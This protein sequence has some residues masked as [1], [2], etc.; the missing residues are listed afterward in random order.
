MNRR[1]FLSVGAAAVA[2]G[3]L[4]SSTGVR[5]SQATDTSPRTSTRT[6][7]VSASPPFP[8]VDTHQHL[9]DLT[10]FTLPWQKDAPKLQRSFLPSDYRQATAAHNVAATVYMEVDVEVAQQNAEADYVLELCS[11]DDNPMAGA[12]ISGRPA[13]PAFPQYMA[14]FKDDVQI[15]GIR[16]VLHGGGTPPGFCLAPEFVKGIQ[17]LGE[18]GKS[19]DLCMRS[20]ELRDADKLVSQCPRT[21]FIVDHCGNMSVTDKDAANRVK[22]L[23]GMKALAQRDNVVC[24]VSGIIASAPENWTPAD[25]APNVLDTIRVFGMDRVMFAGDWPVCT[26]RAELG[27]WIDCL[28]EIVKDCSEMDRAKLFHDNAVAFYKLPKKS[29]SV[30]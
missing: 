8:I 5:L 11:R 20:G 18:I 23:D 12:V 28:A 21:R 17:H 4:V 24:K 3:S 27:Q 1:E 22:W 19:F 10:R 29:W 14:R 7:N 15:K 26:L 6:G 9:W 2:A 25:L 16:Q 30:K 13:D